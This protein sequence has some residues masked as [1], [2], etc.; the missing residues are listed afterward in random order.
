ME[1]TEA[2]EVNVKQL[3]SLEMPGKGNEDNCDVEDLKK[4]KKS[5]ILKG[6]YYLGKIIV[7][8]LLLIHGTPPYKC[9]FKSTSSPK[10]RS[11]FG[12]GVSQSTRTVE[13]ILGYQ[14]GNSKNG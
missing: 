4:K 14:F 12:L 11:K 8:V 9:V 13:M 5:S 7:S 10:R 1:N 3:L 2:D 6:R